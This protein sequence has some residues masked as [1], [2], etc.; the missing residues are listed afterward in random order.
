M[1]IKHLVKALDGDLVPPTGQSV[2]VTLKYFLRQA[3][4]IKAQLHQ[5][6]SNKQDIATAVLHLWAN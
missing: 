2:E 5:Q 4:L 1:Y 3:W 6:P